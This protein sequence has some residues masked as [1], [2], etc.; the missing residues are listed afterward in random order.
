MPLWQKINLSFD[1]SSWTNMTHEQVHC[2][3][4]FLKAS[5]HISPPPGLA[6]SVIPTSF[7]LKV[8]K[9][10]LKQFQKLRKRWNLTHKLAKSVKIATEEYW[11]DLALKFGSF[12]TGSHFL[13]K[14]RRKKI[15]I[16]YQKHPHENSNWIPMHKK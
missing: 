3:F 10:V 9:T 13:N 7:E 11:S 14:K 15:Q 16:Y 12:S 6:T 1:S 5:A 4:N 2:T 8:S